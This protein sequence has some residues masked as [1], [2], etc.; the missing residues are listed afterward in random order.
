MAVAEVPEELNLAVLHEA[1][2]AVVPDREC[3]VWRDRRLSWA[4]VTDRSRRLAAV[5]RGGG[6]G[7]HRAL[8]EC[9]GWESPHDHVAL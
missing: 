8:D 5:L 7:V 4:D 6:L 1:I 3:F 2:A 9:Q